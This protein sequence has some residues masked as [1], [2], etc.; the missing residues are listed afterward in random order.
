MLA[1]RH[2]RACIHAAQA[3]PS[4]ECARAVP[5]CADRSCTRWSGSATT[6]PRAS[7]ATPSVPSSRGR[8]ST[9]STAQSP[10]ADV[11]ES[12]AAQMW[13]SRSRRRCGRVSP[14]ADVGESV[15]AQTGGRAAVRTSAL[16]HRTDRGRPVR[17]LTVQVR[18]LLSRAGERV[19]AGAVDSPQ[20]RAGRAAAPHQAWH[21]AGSAA[22]QPAP[23]ARGSRDETGAEGGRGG[24]EGEGRLHRAC[25]GCA[26]V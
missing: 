26:G 4:G 22:V 17:N 18:R 15:A 16:V 8:S 24:W 12:V 10:G 5:H 11:G 25:G 19:A 20:A 3:R 6:A 7:I 13:A 9:G 2:A 21:W 23:D 14:G 1:R